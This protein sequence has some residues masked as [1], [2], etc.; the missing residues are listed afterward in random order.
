MTIDKRIRFGGGGSQ[1]HLGGQYQGGSKG[2]SKDKGTGGSKGNFGK[3]GGGQ[4]YNVYE[5]PTKNTYTSET[6]DSKPIR[7]SD[8][9]RA[10]NDF[11]NNL[12][13]NN[14]LR[15]QQNNTRFQPYQGGA[16]AI[17]RMKQSSPVSGIMRLLAGLAI[18]GGSFLMNSKGMLSD[19]IMALNNKIRN[20]DLA[21][22]RNLMDYLN[23]K[24]LGG[25]E[26]ME[27]KRAATMQSAKE[28]QAAIDAGEY[29]GMGVRPVQTFE[30]DS[31][32]FNTE[33]VASTP[34]IIE[35][36]GIENIKRNIEE[37]RKF[38]SIKGQVAELTPKQKNFIKS[39]QFALKENL[40]DAGDVY[41]TITNPDL[42]I[43]D[44]GTMGFF[45]QE[46]TTL[47][48]YNEFLESLG[49]NQRAV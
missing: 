27:K 2:G 39:K 28:L 34:N 6:I 17:D 33:P 38:D 37:A 43:Y 31:S 19:G 7:G 46:P 10:R 1:D 13:Q 11:I 24:R 42:N 4:E 26:E 16:F 45:E 48:E 47:E 20:T 3:G 22:S 8:F 49:I 40:I 9:Q 44:S 36:I 23:I 18:P 30:F 25:Y 29:D 14:F 12:N 35:D 5:A 41:K 15:A 21:Q 32:K